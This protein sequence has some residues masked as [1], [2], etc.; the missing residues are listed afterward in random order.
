[1]PRKLAISTQLKNALEENQKLKKELKEAI[2]Y[3]ETY[4]KANEEGIKEIEQMHLLLDAIPESIGRETEEDDTWKRTKRTIST[5]LGA[6]L[7]TS[8]T[9]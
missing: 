8:Y 5:R 1:M 4:K 6:W 3:K 7:A 9:R 2:D